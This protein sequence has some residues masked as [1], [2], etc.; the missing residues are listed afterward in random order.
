[1]LIFITDI[2]R[3]SISSYSDEDSPNFKTIVVFDCRGAEAIDYDAR[4]RIFMFAL[5]FQLHVFQDSVTEGL[6]C[7]LLDGF[8][9][10]LFPVF[11][12]FS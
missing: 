4:V 7:T 2:I 8:C 5:V 10:K 9:D 3:E 6:C 11:L 1:M 12:V